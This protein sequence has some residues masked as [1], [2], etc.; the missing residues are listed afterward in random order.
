MVPIIVMHLRFLWNIVSFRIS[1][2]VIC[3]SPLHRSMTS[4]WPP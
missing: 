4:G 1:A 3:R 2:L